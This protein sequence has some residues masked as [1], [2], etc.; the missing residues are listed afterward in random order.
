MLSQA[1]QTNADHLIYM[2]VPRDYYNAKYVIDSKRGLRS[3]VLTT[4]AHQAGLRIAPWELGTQLR[5]SPELVVL[6]FRGI[7]VKSHVSV[8][9]QDLICREKCRG[10]MVTSRVY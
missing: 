3:K 7:T 10:R 9:V 4:A 2:V 8:Q 1:P 5:S 6:L